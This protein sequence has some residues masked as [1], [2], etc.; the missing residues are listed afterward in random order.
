MQCNV[1]QVG[2]LEFALINGLNCGVLDNDKDDA[3][4]SGNTG[5]NGG[6]GNGDGGGGG[7]SVAFFQVAA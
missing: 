4:G 2:D 5:G 1:P 6:N 3:D 7:G